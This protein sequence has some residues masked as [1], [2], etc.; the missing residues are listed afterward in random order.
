MLLFAKHY[1]SIYIFCLILSL[2]QSYEMDCYYD[3]HFTDENTKAEG[4]EKGVCPTA[5]KEW[6]LRLDQN[7]WPKSKRVKMK[8]E[9]MEEVPSYP[10]Q[11]PLLIPD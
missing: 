6:G 9:Y 11:D 4:E 10:G 2:K 3:N 5:S 8:M 1:L 7:L